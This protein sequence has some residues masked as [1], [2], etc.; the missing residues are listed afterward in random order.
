VRSLGALESAW[1]G[2]ETR[3]RLI[4]ERS[5]EEN[6]RLRSDSRRTSSSWGSI[7]LAKAVDEL[8]GLKAHLV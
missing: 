6:V 2:V 4:P 5:K 7:T 8:I 3:E 1:K